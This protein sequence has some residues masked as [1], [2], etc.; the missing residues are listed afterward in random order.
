M[1]VTAFRE[2]PLHARPIN[3]EPTMHKPVALAAVL[4]LTA[5]GQKLKP[6]EIR[7]AMPVANVL[8]ITAPNP[9][10]AAGRLAGQGG[11][12]LAVAPAP[13]ARSPL[14][15]SSWLF[16]VAV[17]G[18]V[19]WTLAP[20]TWF[21]QAV[22]PTSCD[23]DSCTWG[24]GSGAADLNVWKLV[25]TRAGDAYDYTLSGAPRSTGGTHFVPVISGKAWPGALP[26][27]GHGSFHVDFD[28]VWAGLDHAVGEVQQDFGTIAVTYD[29]RTN[30]VLDVTFLDARN[31]D[32][33]G[34]DPAS[35]N[36]L[37]AVYAF[38]TSLTGGDL[39]VGWRTLPA[40]VTERKAS[41][42]T[43]WLAGSG[44]RAEASF[45]TTGASVAQTECWD[46]PPGYLMTFDALGGTGSVAACLI[47]TA[48]PPTIAIP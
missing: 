24:P 8:E 18:G 34:L 21:T 30:V 36:R 33:P 23:T 15:V 13:G 19:F 31:G 35:P 28:A 12:M 38:T 6:E 17:N 32:D 45:V 39:Q 26:N 14:A 40:G 5:C 48:E 1:A 29:A 42:H 7:H 3:Q 22:P 44:G 43:R 47:T 37:N 2:G 4:L 9:S 46:G 11:P 25:V 41:L 16:A 20:I 10:G 27:R